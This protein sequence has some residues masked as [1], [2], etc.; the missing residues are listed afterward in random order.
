MT[1]RSVCAVLRPSVLNGT[2]ISMACSTFLS[3]ALSGAGE[4]SAVVISEFQRGV[5]GLAR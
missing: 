3:V 2:V 1:H 4:I 5:E